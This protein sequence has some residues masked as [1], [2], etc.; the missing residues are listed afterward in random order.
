MGTLEP[1]AF[2]RALVDLDPDA[3]TQFVADLWN[4][5]GQ[6][7]TIAAR[8][9]VRVTNGTHTAQEFLIRPRLRWLVWSLLTPG[10]DRVAEADAVVTN[11]KTSP[12][13]AIA[14]G[15]DTSVFDPTDLDQIATYALPEQRRT[16][17]YREHF[18][19]LPPEGT[20][21]G[22]D[23]A[24]NPL[25]RVGSKISP[26]LP[27]V[28]RRHVSI[29]NAA[30]L[31]CCSLLAVGVGLPHPVID[32]GADGEAT[33]VPTV[34]GADRPPYVEALANGNVSRLLVRH[35]QSLASGSAGLLVTLEGT[36]DRVLT[37][38]RWERGY[39]RLSDAGDGAWDLTVSGII[40]PTTIGGELRE[41]NLTL[42]GT[43]QGCEMDSMSENDAYLKEALCSAVAAEDPVVVA[44]SA[45]IDRYLNGEQLATENVEKGQGG[46]FAVVSSEP[47]ADIAPGVRNY[48]ARAV[49]SPEG[50]VRT[51]TVS[52]SVPA[53]AG[54]S[55]RI[56][57]VQ[58]ANRTT[59]E[60]G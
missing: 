60:A 1:R 22:A 4:E 55:R 23:C 41:I 10:R 54:E 46:V 35:R 47:P 16:A 48:T 52:Y 5:R 7:A 53:D 17:L 8:R 38:R 19:D 27:F 29:R 28:P 24:A 15:S 12:L 49:V 58:V 11:S 32:P 18:G 9:V 14:V 40:T 20:A 51:V 43:G 2:E 44:S 56:L 59:R 25:D 13:V 45:Y 6:S 31:L 42:A 30:I 57:T 34:D 26:V 3:L 33:G 36:S 39:V 37:Q 50:L 21:T